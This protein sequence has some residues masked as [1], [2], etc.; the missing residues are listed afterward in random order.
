[1]KN[2]ETFEAQELAKRALLGK[3][4]SFRPSRGHEASQLLRTKNAIHAAVTGLE[5]S[6]DRLE[7]EQLKKQIDAV[8][9]KVSQAYSVLKTGDIP[10]LDLSEAKFD[11]EAHAK[12]RGEDA[13]WKKPSKVTKDIGPSS[14]ESNQQQP[15]DDRSNPSLRMHAKNMDMLSPPSRSAKE[16]NAKKKHMKAEQSIM[17]QAIIQ[18]NQKSGPS[19][20]MS[21]ELSQEQER[22]AL[23]QK[24]RRRRRSRSSSTTPNTNQVQVEP[25][26]MQ[27][28]Q[29]LEAEAI[30]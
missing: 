12:G 6:L 8:S 28:D 18:S 30:E 17:K 21:S 16:A 3:K 26:Q 4:T 5:G 27:Q 10:D 29:V 22:A 15:K 13:A 24:K 19:A 20:A 25:L 23:E 2:L 7:K 1:M 14:R 11:I 9:M